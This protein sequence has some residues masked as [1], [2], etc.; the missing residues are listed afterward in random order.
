MAEVNYNQHVDGNMIL[1]NSA[2]ED[3][4]DQF[5]SLTES[6]SKKLSKYK[7]TGRVKQTTPKQINSDI[8]PSNVLPQRLR[9]HSKRSNP[10]APNNTEDSEEE[11]VFKQ[12]VVK[13]LNKQFEQTDSTEETQQASSVS[14]SKCFAKQ[15]E[16]I[17]KC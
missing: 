3:Y 7:Y 4:L 17:T 16:C 5:P 6:A 10:S 11:I 14:G 2:W 8:Q 9:S 15:C 1:P 13:N 12:S